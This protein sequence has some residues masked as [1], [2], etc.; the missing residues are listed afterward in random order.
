MGIP[1]YVAA[2]GFVVYW[3][4]QTVELYLQA[5]RDT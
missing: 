2:N 3:V 5:W 4:A 1:V